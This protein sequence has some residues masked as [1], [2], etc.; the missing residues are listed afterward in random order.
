[1]VLYKLVDNLQH[2]AWKYL[3]PETSGQHPQPVPR[4]PPAASR[5]STGCWAT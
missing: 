5:S 3:D 4:W 2:K 1:M